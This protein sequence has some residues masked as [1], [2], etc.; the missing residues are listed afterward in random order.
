MVKGIVGASCID[1]HILPRS[2]G[3]SSLHATATIARE[4]GPAHGKAGRIQLLQ[5]RAAIVRHLRHAGG[6]CLRHANCHC[7]GNP[8][9]RHAARRC[10]LKQLRELAQWRDSRIRHATAPRCSSLYQRATPRPAS[11]GGLALTIQLSWLQQRAPENPTRPYVCA[12]P[13]AGDAQRGIKHAVAG[14]TV[15]VD[16]F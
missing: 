3:Y 16:F 6:T 7:Q 12:T 4:T 2:P 5:L 14:K 10:M 11:A 8:A 15:G 9:S 1:Q 13:C